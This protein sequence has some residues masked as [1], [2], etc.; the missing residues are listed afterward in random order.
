MNKL[1]ASLSLRSK[2]WLGL[3]GMFFILLVGSAISAI[4]LTHFSHEL[5]RL[6]RENYDSEVYCDQMTD[7]LDRLD[8]SAR[9]LAW[10]EAGPSV[11]VAGQ[12]QRF[13]ENLNK[14]MQNISLKGEL[15]AVRT[16]TEQW[17][18]YRRAYDELGVSP[19][20]DRPRL[21][22]KS[23]GIIYAQTRLTARQIAAL[24]MNNVV[25]ADGRVRGTTLQVRNVLLILV[26]A[27]AAL[28]VLVLAAAGTTVLKPLQDLTR[29]GRPRRRGRTRSGRT[30][31]IA[32]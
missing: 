19:P 9:Q 11:D 4:V 30:S 16:L 13:E 29:S 8:A 5:Q 10:N 22:S 2:L 15:E 17:K 27:G 26:G 3:G 12:Q 31:P 7:A 1:L 28:A 14:E 25:S 21:Y 32:R 24:N 18:A 20:G 23:V 6:L